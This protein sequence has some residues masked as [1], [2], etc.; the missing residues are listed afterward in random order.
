[1]AMTYHLHPTVPGRPLLPDTCLTADHTLDRLGH[2]LWE[3]FHHRTVVHDRPCDRLH[4]L[5]R[6][7]GLLSRHEPTDC[8]TQADPGS[9]RRRD[10]AVEDVT[11][12]GRILLVDATT[13]DPAAVTNMNQHISHRTPGAAAEAAAHRKRTEYDGTSNR[14][15]Y[16]FNPLSVEMTGRWG[17]DLSRFF[18]TICGK[19]GDLHDYNTTQHGFFV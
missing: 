18:K 6:S 2:H 17:R 15:T 11:S 12:G 5:Y 10:L 3:Y 13:V 9:Q 16:N 19:A 4:S 14:G 8:L 7:A 1:M